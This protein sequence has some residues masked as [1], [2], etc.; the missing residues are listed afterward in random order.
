MVETAIVIYSHGHRNQMAI[1]WWVNDT[2]G[3]TNVIGEIHVRMLLHPTQFPHG[4]PL[5]LNPGHCGEEPETKTLSHGKCLNS[6]Y[7]Y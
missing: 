1:E 5:D 6:Y 3:K 4:L 2:V 7:Y